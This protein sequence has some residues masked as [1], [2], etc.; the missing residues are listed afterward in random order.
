M[1]NWL[2]GK[3]IEWLVRITERELYATPVKPLD[4]DKLRNFLVFLYDSPFFLPY[5]VDRETRIVHLQADKWT[6]ERAGQ[7]AE[8]AI[9]YQ[10]AKAA[11]EKH[12][13]ILAQKQQ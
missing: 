4:E 5:I 2:R 12:K 8:N 9:L 7:R 6:A 1:Y 10:R 11:F 3:C 13:K